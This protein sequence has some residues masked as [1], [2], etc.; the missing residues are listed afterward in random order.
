MTDLRPSGAD[1]AGYVALRAIAWANAP[2]V[3]DGRL[4][5]MLTARSPA[6]H[7]WT[8]DELALSIRRMA[9]A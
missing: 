4:V 5:V 9:L 3:Q 1:Q 7:A 6:A 2:L 8:A